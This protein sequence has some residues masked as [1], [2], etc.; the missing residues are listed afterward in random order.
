MEELIKTNYWI[1]LMPSQ[2]R[3][4]WIISSKSKLKIF[5]IDMKS[6]QWETLISPKSVGRHSDK[7]GYSRK[8]LICLADNFLLQRVG[9]C[10]R[11]CL[12][13][14]TNQWRGSWR[15]IIN[16]RSTGGTNHKSLRNICKP[17]EKKIKWKEDYMPG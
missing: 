5:Q 2:T 4:I 3:K 17:K 6:E 11:P 10:V 16:S 15:G 1:L 14:G 12:W 8:F 13:L 9:K 7:H